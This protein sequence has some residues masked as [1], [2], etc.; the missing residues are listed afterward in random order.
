MGKASGM[1]CVLFCASLAAQ[2]ECPPYSSYWAANFA[3][4][5]PYALT[6]TSMWTPGL[7]TPGVCYDGSCFFHADF[8]V[9]IWMQAAPGLA[10]RACA[11][12][13]LGQ[14]C[15]PFPIPH[16]PNLPTFTQAANGPFHWSLKCGG[17]IELELQYQE[18][19]AGVWLPLAKATLI[20][21]G[22]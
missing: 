9:E 19:Q 4:T 15:G 14:V 21:V 17:G 3:Q 16:D 13:G 11:H 7:E 22:C 18:P 5:Q 2:G 10:V 8:S 6:V 1:I 20:C 12:Q